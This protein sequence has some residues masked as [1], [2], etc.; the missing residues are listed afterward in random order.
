M[1]KTKKAISSAVAAAALGTG[2]Y[3]VSS[4]KDEIQPS[5]KINYVDNIEAI[6]VKIHKVKLPKVNTLKVKPTPI[7]G[8]FVT[9]EI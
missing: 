1:N 5:D 7:S 8:V 3:F 4:D 9:K 2:L 6:D